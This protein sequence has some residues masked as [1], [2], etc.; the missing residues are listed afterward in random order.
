MLSVQT[1]EK[2][3]T[4]ADEI[5]RREGCFL[6]DI[7]FSGNP[8]S[9]ILRVYIDTEVNQVSV[10]Q[11]ANVSNG[12][13]LILDVEDVIP[14]GS[15]ELEVSSPGVERILRE[16]WHFKKVVGEQVKVLTFDPVNSSDKSCAELKSFTGELIH[17]DDQNVQFRFKEEVISIDYKNIK[18]AQVVFS[19]KKNEKKR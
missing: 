5:S 11:C 10:D 1:V 16:P 14:G 8:K 7:E 13:S 9:R 12:L 3:K 4:F 19:I 18:R 17:S 2:I 15:Y 6:Y